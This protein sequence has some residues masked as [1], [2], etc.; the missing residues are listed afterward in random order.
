MGVIYNKSVEYAASC[1]WVGVLTS[2]GIL[3]LMAGAVLLAYESIN[4]PS[5]K[6]E[7]SEQ[8]QM[9]L[10]TCV[11]GKINFDLYLLKSNNLF[12]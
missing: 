6:A 1:I 9:L 4:M 8:S 2:A 10:H 12:L 3:L 7:N 5:C 11:L